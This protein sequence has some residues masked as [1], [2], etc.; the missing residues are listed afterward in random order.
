ME[1]PLTNASFGGWYRHDF[2][3]ICIQSFYNVV[4]SCLYSLATT[5][6]AET[7]INFIKLDRYMH[8]QFFFYFIFL[9]VL[10]FFS[11]WTSYC[12]WL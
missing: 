3:L 10:L 2:F 7:I 4:N 8:L 6:E 9:I 11:D 5:I 1:R 12:P